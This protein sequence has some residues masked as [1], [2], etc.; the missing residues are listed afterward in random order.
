MKNLNY[1]GMDSHNRPVYEDEDGTLWKDTD[2][3]EDSEPRLFSSFGNTFDGE[4]D[5]PFH[6]EARLLPERKVW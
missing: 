5:N 3:C 2:P 4:P 1:I 6:G